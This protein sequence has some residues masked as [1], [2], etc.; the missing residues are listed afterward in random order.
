MKFSESLQYEVRKLFA[1]LQFCDTVRC[2][3]HLRFLC[4]YPMLVF[5]NVVLL[6]SYALY[7]R[8]Y[9][10][11]EKTDRLPY[12]AQVRNCSLLIMIS[13][14]LL[15]YV[16]V[17]PPTRLWSCY[18]KLLRPSMHSYQISTDRHL[19]CSSSQPL[20]G[21]C[22]HSVRHC[23]CGQSPHR[24]VRDLCG[25]MSHTLP[26][27]LGR[28]FRYIRRIRNMFSSSRR[29]HLLSREHLASRIV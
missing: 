24:S 12:I 15:F 20:L 5:V 2:Y 14:I 26:C 18:W 4:P 3:Y 13:S 10:G 29:D 9:G 6:G 27:N 23:E 21:F 8:Y 22:N 11:H 17:A 1:K 25:C 28:P 19:L 16:I 7:T